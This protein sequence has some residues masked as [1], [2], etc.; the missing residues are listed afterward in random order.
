MARM[1]LRVELIEWLMDEFP[2]LN[3]SQVVLEDITYHDISISSVR[4]LYGHFKRL[5]KK[6]RLKFQRNA[7]CDNFALW[8]W[9]YVSMSQ[10]KKER[11]FQSLAFGVIKFKLSARPEYGNVPQWHMANWFIN[12]DSQIIVWEPQDLG[13]NEIELTEEERESVQLIQSW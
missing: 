9:S 2:S 1:I 4:S 12:E 7:D 11:F 10:A 3:T 8:F 5:I 13:I 6:N